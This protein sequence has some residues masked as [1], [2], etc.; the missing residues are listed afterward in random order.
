MYPKC[1]QR[2]DTEMKQANCQIKINLPKDVKD[3]LALQSEKNLRSQSN[4]IIIS[5]RE[6]MARTTGDADGSPNLNSA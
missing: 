4:E 5:I 1:T 3:W 2:K 6:R